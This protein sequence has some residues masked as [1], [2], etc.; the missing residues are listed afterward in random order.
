MIQYEAAGLQMLLCAHCDAH[1][2]VKAAFTPP[3]PVIRA[4]D[5]R[6]GETT[7]HQALPAT[8]TPTALRRRADSPLAADVRRPI[9]APLTGARARLSATLGGERWDQLIHPRHQSPALGDQVYWKGRSVRSP[10][11]THF[12]APVPVRTIRRGQRENTI[13]PSHGPFPARTNAFASSTP[14]CCSVE[15]TP[16]KI[17]RG[18]LGWEQPRVDLAVAFLRHPPVRRQRACNGG[19]TPRPIPAIRSMLGRGT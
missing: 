6:H 15:L 14:R 8:P 13:V 2:F 3:P 11:H 9:D 5:G 16:Q 18:S 1:N 12:T 7:P 4:R 17:A 10:L 19:R